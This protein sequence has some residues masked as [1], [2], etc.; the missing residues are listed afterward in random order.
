MCLEWNED[1]YCDKPNWQYI[2]FVGQSLGYGF[3]N[4]KK[5]E[6]AEKAIRNLNQLKIQ[7]KTIKVRG[8]HS[9]CDI[10]S[11][12]NTYCPRKIDNKHCYFD[13]S[14]ILNLLA[15]TDS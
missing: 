15:R 5:P 9:H 6:D 10:N 8:A 3:V 1:C 4:Y 2:V 7:N 13:T 14:I 11:S 12:G